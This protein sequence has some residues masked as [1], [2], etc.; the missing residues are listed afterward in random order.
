MSSR[1][2]VCSL[3]SQSWRL[4]SCEHHFAVR[5]IAFQMHQSHLN[6]NQ[7]VNFRRRVAVLQGIA[8]S[9]FCRKIF[10]DSWANVIWLWIPDKHSPTTCKKH[11][12]ADQ[13]PSRWFARDLSWLCRRGGFA[14][15]LNTWTPLWRC[16]VFSI[17][18]RYA[19][20]PVP[21]FWWVKAI[22]CCSANRIPLASRSPS[23]L[24]IPDGMINVDL[25]ESRNL[26]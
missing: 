3:L 2:L 11:Q 21:A 9:L 13:V 15:L 14:N 7:H 19:D 1:C 17:A 8:A 12:R 5:H 6:G 10:S 22:P 23:K 26:P 24:D 18:Q 20:R 4:R 16:C 25:R